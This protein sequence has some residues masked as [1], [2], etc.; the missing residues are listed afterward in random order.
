MPACLAG[1]ESGADEKIIRRNQRTS[2]KRP[3]EELPCKRLAAEAACGKRRSE[4]EA[5]G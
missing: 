3:A 5:M 2:P 1:L 4:H